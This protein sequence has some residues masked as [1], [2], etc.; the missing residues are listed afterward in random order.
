M[1]TL[2]AKRRQLTAGAV[3]GMVLA[4]TVTGCRGWETDAPP[5]H[6]NWNMDTQEKGKAYRKSDFFADG[7]YMRTPPAGTVARGFLKDDDARS[8]GRVDGMAV[9]AFPSGMPDPEVALARGQNRFGIYCSPCHGLAGDGDGIVNQK[10]SVKAPSF[11]DARLK[12]MPV[13]RM[14][15]AILN[16]VNAGNMGSYA[17]QIVEEDRWNVLAYVRALQK[18]RDPSVTLGGKPE[19]KVA[20]DAPPEKKGE[21]LYVSKGCN[22]CHSIDGAKGVGPTWLA[23]NGRT[24]KTSKGLVTVDDAYL[25][26]SIREPG[27]QI[28]EGFP[29]VMPPYPLTDDELKNLIAFIKTL[30]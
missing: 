1:K 27:A 24:E 29:P 7:R 13:G 22:A 30:K 2:H 14:Y 25:T 21:G 4:V 28:V 26:E 9:T 16:G 18:Q 20:D 10:L 5:V 15:E 8:F 17:G 23:L 11:H 19:V 3:L 12:D 6:L